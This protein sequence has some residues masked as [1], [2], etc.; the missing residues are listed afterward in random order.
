MAAL[1]IQCKPQFINQGPTATQGGVEA[2]CWMSTG[3]CL[4]LGRHQE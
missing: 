1:R 3:G 4:H 2:L